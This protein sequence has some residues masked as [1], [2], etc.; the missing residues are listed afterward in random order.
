MG[1]LADEGCQQAG[2]DE[3]VSDR[4]PYDGKPYYCVTCGLGFGEYIAC[5]EAGCKLESIEA[6]QARK[7]DTTEARTG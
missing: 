3:A 4:T 6:A 7:P 5:E 2:G 1:H